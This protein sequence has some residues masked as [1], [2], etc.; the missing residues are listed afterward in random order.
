VTRVRQCGSGAARAGQAF[1]LFRI[2]L[3]LVVRFLQLLHQALVSG[4][5]R[6]GAPGGQGIDGQKGIQGGM[7]HRE[8][9]GL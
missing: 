9:E 4:A 6:L 2:G 3:Q 5:G 1:M 7:Y 8:G